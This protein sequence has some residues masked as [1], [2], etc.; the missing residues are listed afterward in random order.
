MRDPKHEN[1]YQGMTIYQADEIICQDIVLTRARSYLF[2][3]EWDLRGVLHV[4]AGA[5]MMP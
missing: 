4:D 5:M 2:C 3:H 1:A